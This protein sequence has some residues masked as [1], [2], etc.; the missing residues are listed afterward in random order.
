MR[1]TY[2]LISDGA[3]TTGKLADWS[4]NGSKIVDFSITDAKIS[5]YAVSTTKIADGA[6]T[7]AKISGPI[8]GAKLG[9]HTHSGIDITDGTVTASKISDGAITDAKI[10]G[11][12]SASKLEKPANVVVVAKSGGDFT[13]I[14]TAIDSINPTV[15]NPYLIKVMPGTY[16]ESV[17][18]KSYINLQGAGAE[19]TTI[20]SD[21]WAISLGSVTNSTISNFTLKGEYGGVYSGGSTAV[22]TNNVIVGG[23]WSTGITL[24]RGSNVQITKNTISGTRIQCISVW[25][26]SY[27]VISDNTITACG[28][29]LPG[30]AHGVVVS[31]GLSGSGPGSTAI[32]TG[33]TITGNSASG[34]WIGYNSSAKILRNWVTDNGTYHPAYTDISVE[35]TGSAAHISFNVINSYNGPSGSVGGMYNV[36]AA[37]TPVDIP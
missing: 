33:N 32:I 24:D 4:V 14:Q 1:K 6:V 17:T 2:S 5:S 20:E 35:G 16:N 21:V 8:S 30:G 28:T 23:A 29:S 18:M 15:D 31:D 22:I 26:G 37:G 13:S 10:T 9:A 11:P 27:S 34:I 12:I 7:D 3:V 36:T 25:Y 19:I